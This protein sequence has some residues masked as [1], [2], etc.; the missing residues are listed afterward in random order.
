MVAAAYLG[1]IAVLGVGMLTDE[2]WRTLL[3]V[4]FALSFS[5]TVF[6]VK[7]L[8]ERGGTV[9]LSGRTAIGIL[10]SRTSLPSSS[11]R[12]CTASCPARG[13]LP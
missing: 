9:S 2:D 1:L 5:S 6:V 7:Q 10:S 12:S 11:W 8:D 13:P 4:G 3:L